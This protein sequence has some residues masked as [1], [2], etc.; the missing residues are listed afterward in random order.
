MPVLVFILLLLLRW[1]L[2]F[3]GAVVVTFAVLAAIANP[4]FWPIVW[5]IF[6]AVL[7]FSPSSNPS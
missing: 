5:A 4:T 7:I 3:I 1:G 6:I 2:M